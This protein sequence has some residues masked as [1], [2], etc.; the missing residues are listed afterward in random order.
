MSMVSVPIVIAGVGTGALY[1]VNALALTVSYRVSRVLNL[2]QGSVG[3]LAA[4]VTARLHG[5]PTAVAAAVGIAV[6]A[7]AGLGLERSTRSPDPLARLTSITGWLLLLSGVLGLGTFD[8]LSPR[9]PLGNGAVHVAGVALGYDT[10]VLVAL[11]V[12]V[13]VLLERWL[14]TA[15]SGAVVTAVADA[16]DASA[17]LGL[18]VVRTRRLVWVVTQAA[19]GLVGVLAAPTQGLEPI[20]ALVL[21]AG[22]LA[23]ALLGGIDRL[24]GPVAAAFGLGVLSAVL[25]GRVAPAFVDAAL[26]MVVVIALALR[27][28]VGGAIA[29]ARV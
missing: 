1:A 8:D 23:A 13:P 12:A 24:A 7:L 26:V 28:E 17:A 9:L 27:R 22:G 29:G 18:D 5:L 16:P 19:V 14:A 11:A 6:A 3:L 21:L 2:A 10:I 4:T 20:T 25:G 15:P